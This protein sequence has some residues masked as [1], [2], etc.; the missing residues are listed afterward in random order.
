MS[1]DEQVDE[2]ENEDT[3][4]S[5]LKEDGI[6]VTRENYLR[7]SYFGQLPEEWNALYEAELP[8]ELQEWDQTKWPALNALAQRPEQ[9]AIRIRQ[10]DIVAA[11]PQLTDDWLEEMEQST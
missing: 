11:Y 9:S 1:Q 6:P 5:W 3:V 2:D 10:A 8:R 4:L 7:L